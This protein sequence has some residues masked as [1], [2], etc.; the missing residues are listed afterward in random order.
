MSI[1]YLNSNNNNKQKTTKPNREG[2]GEKQSLFFFCAADQM[3]ER[4]LLSSSRRCTYD[5]HVLQCT[6]EE[7]KKKWKA[8]AFFPLQASLSLF[9]FFFYWFLA[10]L[11]I[12]SYEETLCQRF[13]ALHSRAFFT[14]LSDRVISK[15]PHTCLQVRTICIDRK[16]SLADPFLLSFISSVLRNSK[17]FPFHVTKK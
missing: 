14:F 2:I 5:Y 12:F 10:L 7:E 4:H 11:L 16:L 8:T 9:P 15:E 13:A 17:L 6:E 1:G 3:V